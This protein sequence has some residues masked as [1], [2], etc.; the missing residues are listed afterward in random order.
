MRVTKSKVCLILETF[1]DT[2]GF[3]TRILS[4]KPAPNHMVSFDV[5]SLFTNIPI[6]FVIDQILEKS[7]SSVQFIISAHEKKGTLGI[8]AKEQSSPSLLLP[9]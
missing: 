9:Q 6:D 8:T 5:K 3:V 7:F 4:S 1:K 2:F